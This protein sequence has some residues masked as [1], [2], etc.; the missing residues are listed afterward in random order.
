MLRVAAPAL[1][2][3][4]S[5]ALFTF[6]DM[7]LLVNLMP[8]TFKF[9]FWHLFIMNQNLFTPILDNLSNPFLRHFLLLHPK[10]MEYF[11]HYLA[12]EN[13]LHFYTTAS[14]I[15]VASSLVSPLTFLITS[16]TGLLLPG[17]N[18]LLSRAIGVKNY[19]QQVKV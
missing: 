3:S 6:L 4:F 1:L 8:E 2:M 18:V 14:T 9:D 7:L 12:N 5:T 16:I 11:I 10:Q 13:S 19:L 17:G 15:R